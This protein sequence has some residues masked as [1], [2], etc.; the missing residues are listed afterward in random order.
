MFCA[1]TNAIN[2]IKNDAFIIKGNIYNLFTNYLT[3]L[4]FNKQTN[5]HHPPFQDVTY[6]DLP[7]TAGPG[8]LGSITGPA[9]LEHTARVGLLQ[10]VRP[11]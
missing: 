2:L 6:K 4:T 1:V 9:Q 3:F 8:H 5:Q 11:L 10:G 7:I